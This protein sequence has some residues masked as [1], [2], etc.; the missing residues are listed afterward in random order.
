MLIFPTWCLLCTFSDQTFVFCHA[1]YKP[2]IIQFHFWLPSFKHIY[3]P[4]GWF[5]FIYIFLLACEMIFLQDSCTQIRFHVCTVILLTVGLVS[6]ITRSHISGTCC[7]HVH[8]DQKTKLTY[9]STRGKKSEVYPQAYIHRYI[10]R[11]RES[12]DSNREFRCK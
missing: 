4:V 2:H 8:C 3:P 7:V 1:P 6:R 9:Y 5:F 12:A 10:E 11:E